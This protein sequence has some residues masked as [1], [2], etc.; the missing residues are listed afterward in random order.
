MN[1]IIVA[2]DGFSSSG[3]STIAKTLASYAGYVY[4]DTGAM[5]RAMALFALKNGLVTENEIFEVKL[6]SLISKTAITFEK[7]ENGKQYTCLNGQNVEDKIRTLEAGNAA[8]RISTVGF[9]RQELVRQQQLMGKEKGIVM[10]GRDIGSVVFPN[11]ELKIFVTADI[12]IRAERRYKELLASGQKID[13]HEVLENL[14]ERDF[15]DT[16]RKESPLIRTD[17]AILLDNSSLSLVEQQKI[18]YQWFD[19]KVAD[20]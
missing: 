15:R 14:K 4:V 2:I 1:K 11:A 5:Y 17:D 13:F 7:D 19:K 3:K 18:V 16:H 10:D 12:E 6:K 8:S 9:V 20:K